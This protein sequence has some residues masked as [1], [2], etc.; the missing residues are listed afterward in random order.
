MNCVSEKIRNN[1]D[2]NYDDS[3]DFTYASTS[4][5]QNY[6]TSDTDSIL[7][8]NIYKSCDVQGDKKLKKKSSSVKAL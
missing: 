8:V 3:V 4:S 2:L 5:H 6:I 7:D 1:I